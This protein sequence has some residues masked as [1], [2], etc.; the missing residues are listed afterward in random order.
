MQAGH[1]VPSAQGRHCPTL[2]ALSGSDCHG[3]FG[4]ELHLGACMILSQHAVNAVMFLPA[5]K[6]LLLKSWLLRRPPKLLWCKVDPVRPRP[7]Y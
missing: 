1:E 3:S 7:G 6:S 2:T 4:E 5:E